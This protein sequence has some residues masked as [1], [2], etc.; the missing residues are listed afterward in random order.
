MAEL[1]PRLLIVDDEI[2]H[3]TLLTHLMEREGFKT[4]VA[5][6]GETALQAIRTEPPDVVLLDVNMPGMDGMQV[7]RIVKEENWEL[8]IIIITAF[9]DIPGAVKAICWAPKTIFRSLLI[10]KN[11]SE[12]C[13]SRS[14]D[15]D[16]RGMHRNKE[17][18]FL[19][20]T[21]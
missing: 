15:K 13:A 14:Y 10:M 16:S 6:D 19:T 21:I 12:S 11:C 2:D 17:R 9:A 5:Y 18:I 4:A 7:L 3:C 20:T 1:T 8:P